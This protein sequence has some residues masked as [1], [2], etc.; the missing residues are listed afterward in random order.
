MNQRVLISRHI[1]GIFAPF[2]NSGAT[3]ESNATFTAAGQFITSATVGFRSP[4]KPSPKRALISSF[5]AYPPFV[6]SMRFCE[7]HAAW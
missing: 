1:G 3:V 6:K 5:H 4:Q 2:Q 7:I